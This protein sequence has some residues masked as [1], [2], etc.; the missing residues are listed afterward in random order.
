M[1]CASAIHSSHRPEW[2]SLCFVWMRVCVCVCATN[3]LVSMLENTESNKVVND[4]FWFLFDLISFWRNW[5]SD[6]SEKRFYVQYNDTTEAFLLSSLTR[7]QHTHTVSLSDVLSSFLSDRTPII[8]G[9]LFVIDRSW[10]NHLGKYDTA[11][12]IWGG[13]NFGEWLTNGKWL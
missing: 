1:T 10:F 2:F 5:S 8:A 11:M 7:N 12:D 9:G 6:I 13:E 3:K 4:Y